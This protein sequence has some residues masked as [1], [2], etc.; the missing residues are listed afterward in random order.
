M[1]LQFDAKQTPD[2][3]K[4]HVFLVLLLGVFGLA[5]VLL[6][7]LYHK[8]NEEYAINE[9]E[10]LVRDALLT[11][12]AVHKYVNS[13]SRPEIFRLKDEGYLYK[14]Y[15]SP[16]TMSFTYT[17]RGIKKFLNEERKKIGLSEI[18]FKLASSNP[19]NEINRADAFEA[20]LLRK[21]NEGNLEEY[22]EVSEDSNGEKS[23]Y[24]AM[25]TK[26]ITKGC[27]K[28]HGDPEDAPN[29]MVSQYPESVGYYEKEGT[30]RALISIKVPL[31][32]YLQEGK[33]ASNTLTMVTFIVLALV[34][35]LLFFFIIRNDR[36]Q[37]IIMEK[38]KQLEYA[39][40]T[41]YLTKIYNRMG[42]MQFTEHA[43]KAAV[44]YEKPFSLIM[45]DLDYFKNV[46]DEYG[47]QEGDDALREL[48]EF[49]NKR[50]RSSD[51]FGRF[52]G[53]EFIIASVEQNL[54]GAFKLAE[55]IR[56][57][58]SE[59]R[60]SS[61]LQFTIS[62]GVAEKSNQKTLSDLIQNADIA[63]YKAKELGRNKV[64]TFDEQQV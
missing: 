23:L 43:F 41:D 60:F 25:P 44:R 49:V 5:F 63:L 59:H 45:F 9:A 20:E 33:A 52:G 64:V 3:Q 29:E 48:A 28:C 57:S 18:Y 46:N 21:M 39:S 15:F 42:F 8:H 22:K 26:P 7:Y 16:K 17:A 13:V 14:D 54:S 31:R 50:I 56:K 35:M 55:E 40:T 30:I 27:L 6:S 34:Y 10:K 2:R 32:S 19:R 11:H 4:A 51:I 38:N 12:R 53:E 36:Q 58:V 1:N 37:Q 62:L 61:G 24:F 47:H